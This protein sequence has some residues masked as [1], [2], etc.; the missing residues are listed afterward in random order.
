MLKGKVAARMSVQRAAS[1]AQDAALK[2]QLIAMKQ[3]QYR[4]RER[5]AAKANLI[6][7]TKGARL[8][9]KR[10]A[11]KQASLK[12]FTGTHHTERMA[13]ADD[14]HYMKGKKKGKKH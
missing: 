6:A 3:V 1:K 13:K 14:R 12:K 11:A 10:A 7:K 4:L 8:A 2:R 9:Y 5:I